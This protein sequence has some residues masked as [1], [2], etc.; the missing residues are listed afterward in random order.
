[1]GK[2]KLNT[3][4]LLCLLLQVTVSAKLHS[5]FRHFIIQLN[6]PHRLM[7]CAACRFVW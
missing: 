6:A 2:A 5:N 4:R 1:M 7:V 3:T